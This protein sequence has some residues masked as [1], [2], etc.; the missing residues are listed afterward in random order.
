[1]NVAGQL[2]VLSPE[3]MQ[4]IHEK[5]CEILSKKGVVFESDETIEIFKNHG[6]KVDVYWV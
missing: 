6:F 2:D 5:A 3:Q 1:M 4:T